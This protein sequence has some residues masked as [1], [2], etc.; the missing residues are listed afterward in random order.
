ME[1]LS[2]FKIT[3][4]DDLKDLI[5][6]FPVIEH[7]VHHIYDDPDLKQNVLEDKE[8]FLN[9]IRAFLKLKALTEI[10]KL[11]NLPILLIR[12]SL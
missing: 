2:T 11:P 4:I 6:S 12:D 3:S 8:D 7:M 10:E 1:M 9:E 5:E